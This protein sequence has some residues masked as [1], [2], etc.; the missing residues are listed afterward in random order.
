MVLF[1]PDD[2]KIGL[3]ENA[4]N[5]LFVLPFLIGIYIYLFLKGDTISY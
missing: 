1:I 2:V 4:Y 5:V 3:E